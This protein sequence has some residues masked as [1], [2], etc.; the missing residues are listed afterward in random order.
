MQKSEQ[1]YRLRFL[2]QAATPIPARPA[3][4]NRTVAGS[5]VVLVSTV[6]AAKHKGAANKA[7]QNTI[8][9]I[10]CDPPIATQLNC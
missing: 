8:I 1:A 10:K 9:F 4:S 2:R 3:P 6:V 5:G 7:Q